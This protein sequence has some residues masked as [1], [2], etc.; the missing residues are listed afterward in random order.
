VIADLALEQKPL[1]IGNLITFSVLAGNKGPGAAADVVISDVL[2]ANV[3][4]LYAVSTRGKC[5]YDSA[6][7]RVTCTLSQL[8]RNDVVGVAITVRR[9]PREA[10]VNTVSITSAT[11]DSKPGN[12]SSTVRVS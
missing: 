2:P 7:R 11:T 4:Y 5:S 12:N 1:V 10:V 3:T 9:K 8:K 6:T